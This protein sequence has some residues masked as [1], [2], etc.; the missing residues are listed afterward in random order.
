[1]RRVTVFPISV[2]IGSALVAPVITAQTPPPSITPPLATQN[3]Q[4]VTAEE[5]GRADLAVPLDQVWEL[6]PAAY[7]SLSIPITVREP[8]NHV[9]GAERMRTHH[10][11]GDVRLSKLLDCGDI[12]GTLNADTFDVNLSMLTQLR[13]NSAGGT[14]VITRVD[15]AAKPASTAGQYNSCASTGQLETRLVRYIESQLR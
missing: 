7:A 9:I 6:L 8:A 13:P 11:L 1:M 4:K 15:A 3:L 2:L 12:E 14:T 5:P 10:Y